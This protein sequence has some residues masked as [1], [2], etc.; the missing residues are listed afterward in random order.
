M[1]IARDETFGPVAPVFRFETEEEAIRLA[2]STES[3]LAAYFFTRDL[4][5]QPGGSATHSSSA[6][7]ASTPGL[8]S[9]EGAPFGGVKQSG[10]GREGSR[11][12]IDEY[13]D[14]KYVCVEGIDPGP[15]VT[16]RIGAKVPN[17]GPLPATIGIG[18]MAL[19]LET[20]G[21]DSLWVSDHIVMPAA[22]ESR[23]PFAADGKA[24]WSIGDAVHR[25]ADRPGADRR[26][27]R[28]CDD[29]H[30]R[31]RPAAAQ[32]GRVRE[33]GRLDRRQERRPAQP[34]RGRR[35]AARG[36]R[37]AQCPVR[38]AGRAARG[39][40]GDRAQ[41]AGRAARTHAVPSGTTCPKT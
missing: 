16:M 6:S 17:S 7:S 29:R 23:Y 36:V 12:G 32:P 2:N 5:A 11:H 8:I 27:D 40:D 39:V 28:T 21:F 14:Y 35:L 41:R 15:A 37:G 3:G 13:L 38:A 26:G 25:C 34:R 31:P 4:G 24:T 1:Q 10:L 18:A 20:S 9:Y 19:A 22:I 33:A 30:R